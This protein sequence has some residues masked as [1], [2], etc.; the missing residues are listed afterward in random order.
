[1]ILHATRNAFPRYYIKRHTRYILSSLQF[2]RASDEPGGER[3]SMAIHKVSM[4]SHLETLCHRGGERATRMDGGGGR[5]VADII[6]RMARKRTRKKRRPRKEGRKEGSK[7]YRPLRRAPYRPR[8]NPPR[9]R[10]RSALN[11]ELQP[12]GSRGHDCFKFK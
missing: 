3:E 1:M 8:P 10:G 5:A 7:D 9:R 2:F 12:A 11:S 6:F 4:S